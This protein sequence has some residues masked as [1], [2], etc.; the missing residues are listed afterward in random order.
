MKNKNKFFLYILF[1]LF[2]TFDTSTSNDFEMESK[3]IEFDND[4]KIITATGNV[5][6]KVENGI[7]IKSDKSILNKE[8]SIL[9]ASGNIYFLD[10]KNKIEIFAENIKYEKKKNTIIFK[11]KNETIFDKKFN[12]KSRDI[13]YNKN[14]NLIYSNRKTSL[15]DKNNN[16]LFF[17]N[18]KFN[19]IDKV[20]DVENLQ[21]IDVSNNN[22]K[23]NEAMINLNIGEFI[24]KNVKIFFYKEIF[25]NSENDPRLFG[26]SVIH[27]KNETLVSKGIFTSC[28]IKD[29]EK[30]PPWLIKADQVKH[31]KKNKTIEYKNAWLN[32]YDFPLIYFPFF[33][34]PDPTVKRQSGFLLP[35]L[36]NSSTLGNS[37]QLPYYRVIADN[38]DLTFSPKIFFDDNVL[39][40]SEYRQK[41]KNSELIT[42]QSI[43]FNDDSTRSHFFG[44]FKNSTEN[45]EY[46][47]NIES[48]S[49]KNYLKKYEVTSPLID[50]NM[51][52]NSFISFEKDSDNSY[53]STSFEV[54]EDL[55]KN[56]SDSFEYIYPNYLFN[57]QINSNTP[58]SIEFNTS[59]YQKKYDTNRYDA[60]IV[61][62]I[63]YNSLQNISKTGSI[64]NFSFILKN[65][66]TD[67][68]NSTN[69]GNSLKNKILTSFQID[70]KHPM[71]KETDKYLNYLTPKASLKFSPTETKNIRNEENTVNYLGLFNVDRFNDNQMI[72]GGESLTLG[73][74]YTSKSKQ[75]NKGLGLSIG[76]VY[77]LSENT[78][79]PIASSL[80]QKR[81]DFIG[82]LNYDYSEKLNI[83][84][85]FAIDNNF[86]DTNYDF[87]ETSLSLNKFITSFKFL[88][89]NKAL[90]EKSFISNTSKINFN[91]EHSLNFTTNKNLDENY[92]EYYDLI[93]EYKNDCFAASVEY[94]KSFYNDVDIVAGENIMFSIKIIPF[95]KI[96]TLSLN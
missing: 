90:G 20:V 49:N 41:N 85:S 50:D 28:K 66:N 6:I 68:D 4:G 14:K 23:I 78:D 2:L 48:T 80:G 9:E 88:N 89:T 71:K 7:I 10:E 3:L 54:F 15:N 58:G 36:S 45:Y 33:Y 92:T 62:D 67:G 43:N 11:G 87:I 75:N 95:G 63:K 26:N 31:N 70:T 94:K 79:L 19:I 39:L 83:N 27:N 29:N 65:L 25:G 16:N 38:K 8:D 24:G 40:Q 73:F 91:K 35:K 21:L 12:L 64:N 13:I 1:L 37:I 57:K 52:L 32:V 93:Y 51:N 5:E 60:V 86:Q 76:Q 81:S 77:R 44:N 46:Q 84:Y 18:F 74:D 34:H 42:D 69:H 47:L 59:G 53:F 30:C 72:E 56:D 55:T 82:N 61:N 17:D 96:N 22:Y